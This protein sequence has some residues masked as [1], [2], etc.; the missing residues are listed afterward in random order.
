MTSLYASVILMCKILVSQEKSQ[1][2][3]LLKDYEAETLAE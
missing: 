1:P 3:A 2:I